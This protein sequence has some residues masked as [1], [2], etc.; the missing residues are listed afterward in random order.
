MATYCSAFVIMRGTWKITYGPQLAAASIVAMVSLQ[1]AG[2]GATWLR[3][4]WRGR[5]L[6]VVYAA[7]I[8][9]ITAAVS[10]V[11]QSWARGYVLDTSTNLTNLQSHPA[12]VL[13]MSA[14]VQSSPVELVIIPVLIWAYG[15]LQRWLGRAV[16][17]TTVVLGH[18]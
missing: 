9:V 8:V 7:I 15:A 3:R 16:T 13:L 11:P 18:V 14:F 1:V 17:I 5:D 10:V 2:E 4:L 6:A 12:Y